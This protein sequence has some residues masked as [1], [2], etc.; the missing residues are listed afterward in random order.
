MKISYNQLKQ[1]IDIDTEAQELSRILTDIGLEVEGVEEFESVKGGLEGLVLGEVKTCSKHPNADKL[2]LTTVDTGSGEPLRIVCGA[3]NVAAGQKVVVATIGTHLYFNDQ[4]ITIKKGNIRG[5][6]SEGMI[7]A[8]DEMGL[9]DSHEGI[10]VLPN[11]V[12]IGTLA[13]DYFE[14][15]K[16]II[17]E[18]GLTPNRADGASHIGVARDLVAYF[19]YKGKDIELKKPTVDTFSIDN[20]KLHIPVTIEDTEACKRYAGLT[21]SNIEIKESP[22]WLKNRLKAIGLQ[23]IN[24]V[25]DITNFVMHETGQ[26]LH[27]FDADK[28]IGNKVIVKT[29]DKGTKFI[30]LDEQERE[31][32]HEDLMICNTESGMCIGGVFGGIDSGVS[33]KT[34]IIFLESAY[35]NPVYVRKTSKRHALQTDSS[36]RFER[37]VDP[38]NTIYA[39]K[40]AALL[41]KE[42]AGGSISSEIVDVYPEPIKDFRIE[43]LYAHINRLIGKDIPKDTVRLILKALEIKIVEETDKKLTLDVAPYRVDVTR[44]ADVI[45]EIFRIYGY[46]NIENSSFVKSA[47]SYAPKPDENKL[48]NLISEYL[49]AQGFSEAMSNSLTKADYYEGANEFSADNSVKILNALSNDLNVMR[50]DLLFGSLETV[51]RNINYKNPD[52]QLYEFGNTYQYNHS[53]QYE[54]LS[55]YIEEHHLA[56]TVSGIKRPV[57][58][59]SKETVSDFYFLKSRVDGLLKRLNYDISKL[60]LEETASGIFVYGLNYSINHKILVEFGKLSNKFTSKFGIEQDVFFADFNW[61]RMIKNYKETVNFDAIS[62]FPAVKRDFALLLNRDIKF[63]QIKALAFKTERKLLKEVSVFDVFEDEKLGADKKSY[64]V[65]F[66]IQDETKTLKDKQIEKIMKKLQYNFEKELGAEL[67]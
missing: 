25:V 10:M 5:E 44:E 17:F 58:W 66:I 36:F 20:N 64:A 7:C 26:P 54:T 22:A 38:N 14:I 55:P 63:S 29:L 57:N 43:V 60:K 31:L 8:E 4:E 49:S 50:Q 59:K 52:I 46:N 15:E 51:I 48:R 42:L 33:E 47:I 24:N 32:H 53:D 23:P 6:A 67:R 1:Y 11:D 34:K 13:K 30:T 37:G 45:E 61:D 19:K 27:A 21:I 28:I 3:P 16:D 40:R 35:F 39:L 2:S 41:I 9:G 12:K 62:K 65:S 56:L 18:I